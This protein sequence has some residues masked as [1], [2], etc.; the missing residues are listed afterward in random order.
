MQFNNLIDYI[1]NNREFLSEQSAINEIANFNER[2]LKI[3]M[4]DVEDFVKKNNVKEVT[5]PVF[6]IR[7]GVPT[8]D[9]LLSNEIFGITKEKRGN[10]WAYIDLKG[11]YLHPFIYKIWRCL[12]VR[13]TL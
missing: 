11:H 4:T 2:K 6:F 12:Y 10:I 9:G 8:P 7:N 5:N 1:N 13:S 3:K